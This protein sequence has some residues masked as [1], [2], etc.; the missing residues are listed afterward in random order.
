MA[1]SKELKPVSYRID[2]ETKEKFKQIAKQIA[3][4]Q[5]QDHVNQQETMNTLIN[6]YYLQ[7]K[8]NGLEEFRGTID[9]FQAYIT[10]IVTMY[11]NA[12]EANHK[13][14][15]SVMQEFEELLQSKE[16]TIQDLQKKSEIAEQSE[17]EAKKISNTYA[18]ENE[19]LNEY[20][21]SLQKEYSS[22]L[23]DMQS[24][25]ADKEKANQT[26]TDHSESLKMQLK[27]YEGIEEQLNEL[28]SLKTEN[29]KLQDQ[30]DRKDFEFKKSI[31]EF[32]REK[33]DEIAELKNKH[34]A[35]I[36]YYQNQYKEL[37]E[38]LEK[39]NESISKSSTSTRRKKTVE[40]TAE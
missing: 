37:L 19:R 7:S 1:D 21:E 38:K 32:E 26:L 4:D 25:L 30:L 40:K 9:Q 17:E 18:D 10:S 24:M 35:D 31:L 2:D 14:K 23:D 11:T 8:Q 5:D 28:E 39:K 27:K 3:K 22:K 12:L 16:K 36:E 34:I 15:N 6:A 29:K 13:M 20:I 33:Q